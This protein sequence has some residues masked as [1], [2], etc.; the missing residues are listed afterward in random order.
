M[1]KMT[2]EE[3]VALARSMMEKSGMKVFKGFPEVTPFIPGRRD[4]FRYRDLGMRE[5]SGGRARANQLSAVAGMTEP[6]GWHFHLCEYQ[7]VY[8]LAGKIILEMEDGT[9]CT[10]VAGDAYFIPGGFRHNEIYLSPDR[11]S[12]EFSVPGEIGTVAVPRP[13]GLPEVLRPVSRQA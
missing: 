4:F 12:I 11:Q 3:A 1:S 8:S 5:A 13:E 2:D 10:F 7:F 9:V 6:T